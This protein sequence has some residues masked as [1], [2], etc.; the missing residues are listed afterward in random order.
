MSVV[1]Y[2]QFVILRT[3]SNNSKQIH[4]VFSLLWRYVLLMISS[5]SIDYVMYNHKLTIEY[6]Y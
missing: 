4:H 5:I 3:N 1:V 2:K 6:T